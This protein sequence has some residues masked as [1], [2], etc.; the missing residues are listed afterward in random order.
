MDAIYMIRQLAEMVIYF[1]QFDKPL[2]MCFVY[3]TKAFER[4]RLTDVLH[5][6]NP[7]K[8]TKKIAS[9]V[10]ELITDRNTHIRL[11]N[12]LIDSV[13][14]TLSPTLSLLWC[15]DIILKNI[16]RTRKKYKLAP[17][18]IKIIYYAEEQLFLQKANR[19]S[20]NRYIAFI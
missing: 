20:K 2:Y 9:L 10:E 19:S 11:K 3:M 16:K 1:I 12:K 14:S 6:P 5:P 4:V 13:R 7:N 18:E 15:V 17:I 8:I